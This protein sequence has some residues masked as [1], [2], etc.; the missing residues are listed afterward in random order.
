MGDPMGFA[1]DCDLETT[2]RYR[3]AET[4]HG[5]VAMLSIIGFLVQESGFHPLFEANGKDIGAGIRHLDIVRDASPFFFEALA[6]PSE[7]PKSHAPLP[8]GKSPV[9]PVAGPDFSDRTTTP[10]TSVSTHWASSPPPLKNS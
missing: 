7:E 4:T 10:V 5:R 6:V 1:K 3:E 9:T 8:D 2:K